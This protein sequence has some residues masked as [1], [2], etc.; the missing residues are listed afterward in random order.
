[1]KSLIA[2][3]VALSLMAGKTSAEE[4]KAITHFPMSD[5][6][7]MPGS[8]CYRWRGIQASPGHMGHD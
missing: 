4:G 8:N 7:K 6:N 5:L 1:M 3:L 2:P